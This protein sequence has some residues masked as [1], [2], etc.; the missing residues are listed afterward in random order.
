M[1][2]RAAQFRSRD[3]LHGLCDLLHVLDA[4]NAAPDVDQ[5]RH[6]GLS[7]AYRSLSDTCLRLLFAL[8]RFLSLVGANG[9]WL[10]LLASTGFLRFPL[11]L[12]L[13]RLLT[14]QKALLE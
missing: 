13:T 14:A 8:S 1:L 11:R 5:A 9:L 7:F 4:A 3:H 10:T 6:F 2:L 12:G